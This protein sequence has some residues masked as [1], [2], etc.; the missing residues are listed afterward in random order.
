MTLR[1][2]RP[3]LFGR[4]ALTSVLAA[5]SLWGCAEPTS[6]IGAGE[7]EDTAARLAG[8]SATSTV[9]TLNPGG[10]NTVTDG[11]RISTANGAFQVFRGGS[12]QIYPRTALPGS[13]QFALVTEGELISWQPAGGG[14]FNFN[15]KYEVGGFV[16]WTPVSNTLTELV[17]GTTWR[18]VEVLTGTAADKPYTLTVTTDYTSPNDYAE[19]SAAVTLPSGLTVAPQLYL[20]SDFL[21]NGSDAGPGKTDTLSD[22]KRY[23]VQYQADGLG[24]VTATGGVLEVD[25]FTSWVEA[26]YIC[27]YGGTLFCSDTDANAPYGPGYGPY[28]NTVNPAGGTDAGVGAHWDLAATSGTVTKRVKLYFSSSFPGDDSKI[29]VTASATSV[30]FGGAVPTYTVTYADSKGNE[31]TPPASGWT[32]PTCTSAYT[33]S[34]LP[35][36]LDITCSGAAA[37]GLTF[38][39][40]KGTLTVNRVIPVLTWTGTTGSVAAGS[41]ITLSATVSPATCGP[42][43]YGVNGIENSGTFVT[44]DTAGT[45]T[46]V[47]GVFENSTCESFGIPVIVTTVVAPPPPAV[48]VRYTEG[49]G[50]YTV[51]IGGKSQRIAFDHEVKRV[52][53]F[54]KRTGT[55][56]TVYRGALQWEVS[57]AWRFKGTVA[58]SAEE[59]ALV[60]VPCGGSDPLPTAASPANSTPTAPKCGTFTGT[61]VLSRWNSS[62]KRWEAVGGQRTFTASMVDGGTCNGDFSIAGQNACRGASGQD[63]FGLALGGTVPAG[64]PVS[65]PQPLERSKYGYIVIR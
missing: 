7:A 4:T 11:L 42:V 30:A 61:G 44:P 19:V 2:R 25:K 52:E 46:L 9:N 55:R 5:L 27:V 65:A 28:P 15:A 26:F 23:V 34:S 8:V 57:G 31:W 45:F 35:G 33:T 36:T 54:D 22:G 29:T 64:V 56:T 62:R 12:P 3:I 6:S 50:R 59:P 63:L 37:D 38:E 20:T 60:A 32:A 24:K 48:P 51:V 1:S 53:S 14:G 49:E 21:L 10:G 40:V 39:Y 47:A 43:L 13:M 58:S 17:P 41:T 18:N 16:T